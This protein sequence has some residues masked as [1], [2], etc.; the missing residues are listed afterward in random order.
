M[1]RLR[2]WIDRL[3]SEPFDSLIGHQFRVIVQGAHS[4][5]HAGTLIGLEPL[6]RL[7]PRPGDATPKSALLLR[8]LDSP[9]SGL[10]SGLIANELGALLTLVSGCRI[11]VATELALSAPPSPG[12]Y[13]MAIGGDQT[14]DGPISDSAFAVFSD[15]LSRLSSLDPDDLAALAAA[16]D[17]HYGA[18]ILAEQDKRAAY[19]LLVAG[20]EV[21]SRRFGAPPS[22]WS[23]W[24][25]ACNWEALFDR[26]SLSPPQAQAIRD[27]LMKDRQLRLAATFREYASQ[28]LPNSFWDSSLVTHSYAVHLPQGTRDQL[29][30]DTRDMETLVPRDRHVLGQ[31]LSKTYAL[32]SGVMHRGQEVALFQI[33]VKSGMPISSDQPLPFSV[34]RMTLAALIRHELERLSHPSPLPDIQTA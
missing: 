34:L 24:E 14:V 25:L 32:R 3:G 1:K 28:S 2:A 8:F 22:D 19:V 26:T 16:A 27:H 7:A 21:L 31:A 6:G 18:V 33:G 9:G 29:I 17:L 12:T 10:E 23:D 5:R 20:L 4:R 15:Y 11:E 13:F 30:S